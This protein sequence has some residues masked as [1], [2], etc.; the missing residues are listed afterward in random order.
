MAL[1]R[2]SMSSGGG[3]AQLGYV[4][5]S[6]IISNPYKINFYNIKQSGITKTVYQSSGGITYY[7]D[8]YIK[9]DYANISG[10]KFR[11]TVLQDCILDGSQVT[12]NTSVYWAYNALASHCVEV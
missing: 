11:L 7:E 9:L 3:N 1:I 4:V 5:D 6:N 12:A 8:D 10:W 2:A